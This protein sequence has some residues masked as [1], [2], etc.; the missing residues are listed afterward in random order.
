MYKKL[1]ALSKSFFKTPKNLLICSTAEKLVAWNVELF[2]YLEL[3]W[4]KN[5]LRNQSK[6]PDILGSGTKAFRFR[7]LVKE[8]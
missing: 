2:N 3:L 1:C 4:K 8:N 7:L 5:Y 6:L